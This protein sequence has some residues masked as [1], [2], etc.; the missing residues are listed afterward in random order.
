MKKRLLRILL[1]LALLGAV[2]VLLVYSS[3]EDSPFF[4]PIQDFKILTPLQHVRSEEIKEVLLPYLGSSFW[5]VPLDE[6][7]S[8]LARLDWVDKVTVTRS[9]PDQLYISVQEQ[10]PVARWG[11]EGLVNREGVVFYPNDIKEFSNLIRLDGDL[12]RSSDILLML[13]RIQPKM[14]EAGLDVAA[15]KLRGD[16]VWDIAMQN[17]VE[18][19]LGNENWQEHL[20]RF[21]RALPALSEDLR[22]SARRYDLRYS[23]GFVVGQKDK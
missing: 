11:D 10:F 16:G 13:T 15:V 14:K 17:G 3:K 19:V 9:W 6:I 1:L 4:K 2:G 12:S 5:N 18:V 23:N 7:Q 21:L 20:Q 22:N 8:D